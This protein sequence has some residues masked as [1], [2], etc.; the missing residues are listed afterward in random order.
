MRVRVRVELPLH[1]LGAD[2][3]MDVALPEPEVEMPA[4]LMFDVQAEEHVGQEEHLALGRDRPHDVDRVGR[5]AA[6]VG[7]RF[8]R[9]VGVDIGD[10]DPV[11]VLGAPRTDL[12][13]G[14]RRRERAS[15]QRIGEQHARIRR[16]NR[17]RLGHEVHAAEHDQRR[18]ALRGTLGELERI[19]DEVREILDRGDLIVVGEDQRIAFAPQPC[20]SG[21]ERLVVHRADLSVGL[22]RGGRRRVEHRRLAPRRRPDISGRMRCGLMERLGRSTHASSV[23]LTTTGDEGH[24]SLSR[25]RACPAALRARVLGPAGAGRVALLPSRPGAD[26]GR[27][28]KEPPWRSRNDSSRQPG[29]TAGVIGVVAASA[30]DSVV[31]RGGTATR[32]SPRPGRPLH[33]RERAGHLYRLAGRSPDP[34]VTDDV[35]ADR[36]RSSLGPLEKRLDVPRVH[37]IVEDHVAIVHGDVPNEGAA[38]A[39]ERAIMRISGVKGV[40]SHLHPGLVAG[41]TRPSQGAA[42]PRP[43]S[44]ALTRAR[45]SRRATPAPARTPARRCTQCCAVSPIACP[46][47]NATQVLAHLPSDVRVLAGPVR[48]HGD[49]APRLKTVPQLVAAVIA[50][51]GIDPAHAEQITRAVV[52]TLRGIVRDEAATLP[53]CFRRELRVLWKTEPAALIDGRTR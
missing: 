34:N 35:L 14:H 52:A 10:D 30:P 5:R 39:I 46:K 20:D 11:G 8:H 47:T 40:E 45:S 6:I 31:G 26:N 16:Q 41:D 22:D 19:A 48:R 50:E 23:A 15:G 1:V 49:A 28:R 12:V 18:V 17:G 53:R 42:V 32:G 3:G 38:R 24:Q 43:A 25:A 44:A 51:G 21:D 13:G 9:G 33:G 2:A 29:V 7:L 4:R 36:I 37:V 27:G